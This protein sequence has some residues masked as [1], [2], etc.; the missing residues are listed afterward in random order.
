MPTS[1]LILGESGVGKEMIARAIHANSSRANQQ[2]VKVNCAS[3]PKN[4]FESEFSLGMFADHLLALIVT[5]QDVFS[6]LKAALFFWMKLAKYLW[7][8]K[9]NCYEW[10]KSMSL[11]A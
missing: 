2:L 5:G 8:C 4:L 7:I 9:E 6:W 1:V 3:I 11:S 10:Y